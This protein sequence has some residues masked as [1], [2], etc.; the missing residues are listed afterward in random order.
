MKIK[1]FYKHFNKSD[2]EIYFFRLK[3]YVNQY[4]LTHQSQKKTVF[5]LG[6]Q[7]SGTTLMTEIFNRDFK[8]KVFGEFSELSDLDANKIRLNPYSYVLEKIQK[9]PNSIVVMKPIVES[10]NAIKLLNFFNG[11]K[12]VWLYRNYSSVISSNIKRFGKSN[13]INDIRPIFENEKNNWRSE[14]ISDKTKEIIKEHY[15][16]SMNIFDAAALFWYVRNILFFELHLDNNPNVMLCKYEELVSNPKKMMMKIYSFI[17]DDY[18][19]NKILTT[20][21]TNSLNKG[22]NVEL[23]SPILALVDSLYK[24]LDKQYYNK[25]FKNE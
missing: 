3:K 18:P 1:N 5:I 6:C 2:L 8:T 22:S 24:K 19:G 16:E 14:N 13:G 12:I 4:F 7:R 23:S 25:E 21:H 20:I 10:Q 9:Y 17:E 11:S 15:S